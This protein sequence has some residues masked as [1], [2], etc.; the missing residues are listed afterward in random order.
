MRNSGTSARCLLLLLIAA[1]AL[2]DASQNDDLVFDQDG[3]QSFN[4]APLIETHQQVSI[5]HRL[6]RG[7]WDLFGTASSTA[8]PTTEATADQDEDNAEEELENAPP[9]EPDGEAEPKTSSVKETANLERLVHE[10]GD[11]YEDVEEENEIGNTAEGRREP[12]DFGNTDDEDLAGSGEV[13]GSA[14]DRGIDIHPSARGNRKYYRI[15]LTVGEP[16]RREYADRN[17]RE[18]KELSGNLTQPLEELYN[19]HIP[20]ENHHVNVVKIS[21]TSDSFTSQVTL[22][23]GSTFTDELEV[24]NILEQQLQY[25]S[26]GNIQVGPEGFTFRVFQADRGVDELEC[27][28]ST[29]LRCRDGA[30]V[31]LDSRCDGIAQCEDGSDEFDC[32]RTIPSGQVFYNTVTSSHRGTG[33]HHT[34]VETTTN[35]EE[36]EEGITSRPSVNKCRADDT[37]RCSDG[38]RS[39]CSVQQCDGVPDCDDGG[40][41]VDCPHPG[42]SAGE[43]ACDVSRCILESHRCNFIK[44][45]DDGSDEHDCNYPACTSTQFKCRNGQCIDSSAHCNGVE[46]CRDRTDELNCPCREDQFECTPGFCVTLN[47]RCDRVMDCTN[48]R[49]EE[50][51]S[52][53]TRCRPD[54]FTCSDGG[55]VSEN[56]RCDG[57]SDCRDRSDEY[58]CNVT[59]CSGDQ[60]RCLDG[61]CISIDKR[62]NSYIDCRN[63]EDENQCGCGEAKF[64]CTDGQCIGYELQCNGV[65]ECSD[66]SDE[67]DCGNSE[68]NVINDERLLWK[69]K[70]PMGKRENSAKRWS[71]KKLK[72]QGEN[73]KNDSFSTMQSPKTVE[74]MYSTVSSED[75]YLKTTRNS[76][77]PLKKPKNSTDVQSRRSRKKNRKRLHKKNL[78]NDTL[79]ENEIPMRTEALLLVESTPSATTLNENLTISTSTELNF[80][81]TSSTILKSEQFIEQGN[82]KKLENEVSTTVAST[83]S[84]TEETSELTDDFLSTLT[85]DTIFSEDLDQKLKTTSM[86]TEDTTQWN[87]EEETNFSDSVETPKVNWSSEDLNE[88]STIIPEE[89]TTKFNLELEDSSETLK[90]KRSSKEDL[91]KSL[92]TIFPEEVTELNSEDPSTTSEAIETINYGS[93][94]VSKERSSSREDIYGYKAKKRGD[95]AN[96]FHRYLS[97]SVT[98][99]AST[100]STA[101][102]RYEYNNS[103]VKVESGLFDSGSNI[104]KVDLDLLSK[105]R[106]S[107]EVP[108]NSSLSTTQA[109]KGKVDPC[110]LK[111]V[112][113]YKKLKAYEKEKEKQSNSFNNGTL[114]SEENVDSGLISMEDTT[115]FDLADENCTELILDTEQSTEIFSEIP[116]IIHSITSSTEP[117]D[118]VE[119]IT[120]TEKIE[121]QVG[122]K[123]PKHDKGRRKDKHPKGKGRKRKN[124]HKNRVNKQ[125]T[126]NEQHKTTIGID[127][128]TWKSSTLPYFDVKPTLFEI[129][130]GTY[131][132][133]DVAEFHSK[134]STDQ[135]EKHSQQE[136]TASWWST[137][138][139]FINQPVTKDSSSK[140]CKKGDKKA[141]WWNSGSLFNQNSEEDCEE[142]ASVTNNDLDELKETTTEIF[143]DLF[144]GTTI[145]WP[146]TIIPE[147]FRCNQDQYLCDDE[148]C[149]SGSQVC[150]G[151][152]DCKD[153]SDESN[154]GSHTGGGNRGGSNG[155]TEHPVDCGELSFACDGTCI[156]N[157]FLCDNIRHC[158]DGSDEADCGSEE[159]PDGELPCENG[160][161]INKNFFCDRNPDCHDGSDERDCPVI[162]ETTDAD[163]VACRQDEFACRHG[164]CIPQS[165]VCDGQNDCP[166]Q[167]DEIN[168]PR[169][170]GKDQFQCSNGD[171]IRADQKCNGYID[172]VDGS[173]EPEECERPGFHPMPGR[174][175]AGYIMCVSDKDCVPQSSLCNGIPECRDR[176]DEENCEQLKEPS[177]LNLKTYPSEQVIKENPAK[178]GR[179]VVFQCRDEGPLRARVR[180]LRGNNLPLPPGSRDLNGRL[181]IPN[182]Q[183]DHGGLYICE[184]VGYPASTTGQQVN[185]Y[186]TVEK[187]EPPATNKPH[188]CQYDEATCSNGD[189]IPKS[190]V[191]NGRLDCTDGSDEMRCSPHGCEPNEFRCNNTQ[192][193]SKL[194]RCDGDKDCADGSD[195]ENCVPNR[196]GSP[197]RVTE[198]TCASNDQCIPK[199]YHCDMEKDCIDG[200]DEIGCSPVYIMKPPPPMITLDLGTTLV[201]VCTAIGVPTPEI[202]WRLNWGHIPPKCTMTS[203]NGTGTLTCPDIQTEDQGAYSCEALNTAGFVFAVPDAIVMVNKPDDV[204]PKGTF[205]SEARTVE[206][207]ISCFCFGVAT[208]CHSANLFTYQIPPPFD[209]HKI[210]AVKQQPDL[211]I[212]N[213]IS[214]QLSVKPLGRD[215]LHLD[216]STPFLNQLAAEKD[217]PYFALPE[218]FH[219]SQLKSYGGY[220]KYRVRYNG[221]GVPNSAPAVMLSG[222]N[223]L[224]IHKGKQ[225]IPNYD[226]DESVRFFEGEWLKKQGWSEVPATRE[227]IMMTLANVDNILIK[228]EYDNSP[229]LDVQLTHIVMDTADVRNT[230]LGSASFVEECQCPSG[231]T[232]LSCEECAPGYLRRKTGLWLGQCYRDEPI[233]CPPG[234]YG[235]PSRNIP[236][237]AC[238]CPL[239]NPSNQFARTCHLGSDG[240]PTCNCPPGYIGR[241]CEQCDVGYQGNPLIPGDMCVA[242]QQ[243]DPEGSISSVVDPLT[244]KCRCKQY[245]TGITCNQCKANTFKNQFG[246]TSCF[247][248]GITNKC[249]SSN[250]YRNDV[251]VSFTNSIRDFSLIE[252][253]TPNPPPIVDGIRLNTVTREIIYSDFPNRGN[254]DVYYWQ[255]PSIFLGDQV[256]SYGGNLKYTVRYVPAPGGQSSKNNAAD[257]ELI[258]ANDINLLYFSRES[259]EPNTPQTF[260]VPLLEQYWQRNDGTQA[261]R[262]HLLMALADVSAIRIKATYTTHT[263]EA[264]LSLVSLDI[265]EKYNTGRARAV[266][267]EECSCPIGYKGLSCEDCDVGYTRASE[268]L[269]LGICEQCNCNGHSAQCNPDTGICEN[270]ADH[271]TGDFCEVCEPG[272]EGDAT[273]GT[274]H[275]CVYKDSTPCRCNEAGS[276]SSSCIGDRCD[277]KRNVEGPQCNRCRPSTFGLSSYNPDGCTECYCSGVTNQCHESSLYVQQIPVWVY[278]NQHGFTLT[279]STRQEIIDDGFELNFAMNEIGYRYPDSRGRRLFWSLPAIFTGNKVKS[280]GG[281]LTLTQH[282]TAHPGA[283]SYKDQDIILIG[284]GITLFW[285]NPV[286]IQPD[287]PLT[288]SVPL[289]ESEWR[290]LTTEGPRVASRIDLMTVLSNLEAILVRATHSERMTATYISDISLDTAVEHQTGNRR[291]VQV[292]VCRCPTGHVGT[293]CESCARGYYRDPNDRS[294]SYL[295]SCNP[296]PCNNNEESCEITR[297]G[298]VKCHCLP[299]YTGQYCLSTETNVTTT[300]PYP[301]H[302]PPP[303]ILVYIKGPEFQIVETGSTV[304]YHCA[305]KSLDNGSLHIKWEKEG[306]Q[307][308]PGRTVDD[309]Q[310]LLVIRDV[311]VSDSGVYVCQVSDGVHIGYK[312][313]TLTVGGSNPVAPRAVVMPTSLEVMEGQPAEFRCM[314]T[315][316]PQPQIE[317]I[318]IH[319]PTS[320]EVVTHNGAW[321]LRAA[322]KNDAAEYKCI[323]RNNVG[324]DEQTVILYVTDNPSMPPT[325]GI[326]PTITPSQW[327]GT[328]GDAVLLT[329]SQTS[330]E[331]ASLVWLRQGNLPF[332]STTTQRDGVLTIMNSTQYDSG[333]YICL[334][335]TYVGTHINNTAEITVVPRRSPPSIKVRPEKQT[336]PQGSVAE[337]H[338]VT[339]GEPG[340]Q[341]KWS[342]YHHE[343]LSSNVQQVG[344]TL[345]IVNIQIPDRG[346]YVCHVT[347]PSGSHESSA[348]IEV[349]PREAPRVEIYPREVP[350]V[351]L[352]GST[353]LQC[354]AVAGIP[355]PELHWSHQNGRPF[356]SNIKQLP[357]GVLRLSNI[358]ANDGGAY[359]C[360][361]VNPVGSN[362]AVVYIEVQSVP[363]IMISPRSGILQVK[364][365][366][367]VKLVCRSSGY[368]QPRVA[369][370]KHQNRID[371]RTQIYFLSEAATPLEAVY[372]INSASPDDEG[373]YTCHANNAA[374]MV[375]ERVYIRVEDNEVYPP[376]EEYP[377]PDKSENP[378]D[379]KITVP[380]DYFKIPS[381]GKVEMRCYVRSSDGNHI[382]LDWKRTDHRPLPEG[383]TVHNGILNIPVADK[384][385][386]GEYVCLGMDQARNVL[387]RAKS[388]LEVLSPPRIVLNPPRQTVRAGENPSID[389]STTGDEPMTIQWAAIGRNLPSSVTQDRGVLQFHGITYSDAGKYV[390]TATN[391]AGT[392]EAVAE[393]LVN[394]HPFDESS[395]VH[396]AQRDVV[397]Y[398]GQPVRLR[399]TVNVR[400]TI[401]WSRDGQPLPSTAR[402]EE[403][404]LELPRARPE[405]SGRYICQIQTVH[406]VSSDY[407]NLNVSLVNLHTE[408]SR[409]NRTQ[410]S[411]SKCICNVQGCFLLDYLCNVYIRYYNDI[412][413]NYYN[414]P[415]NRHYL[416][417]R[418]AT[419]TPAVSVEASQNP[420]NIGDTVNIRCACSGTHNPRYHWIRPNHPSLPENAQEYGNVLRLTNVAVSDSGVYRCIADTPEG[421]FDHDFNLVV[422]DGNNDAPAIETKYAPYGSSLE[423]DCKP[424]LNPPLKFHWSKLGGLLPRDAQ[425]FENKLKLINV[426]AEDAGTYVC[427]ATN[428]LENIEIPTVLVVTGVVPY[429]SQAPES[430]I[431]LP[432]LPDSY[433]K[434]NIEISFK[435]E[436]YDGIILYNDESNR[437]N[438]DFILLS[439]VGGYP[440]FSF[441]LGSGPTI[442]R[443]EKSVTLSEWHTIKLQRNRKE[444][445]MLVDGEGPY[446]GVAAGRKQGLDLKALL[447]VGGVPSDNTVNK[448]AEITSG[449]V[450]C[451]SRLVIGEKE[452]DLIDDQ[453]NSVGITNCETCAENPCNNAGVCQEAATKNGYTCLCRAGY[454]GKHCDYVGQSCYPGACG[455]GTCVDK[456]TG[457][458]CYCPHGKTG[459]RCEHSLTIYEPA[460]HDDKSFI[461][462]ET[463]KALRRTRMNPSY[464]HNRLRARNAQVRKARS[465][466]HDHN[467]MH[468]TKH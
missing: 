209:R 256:T 250:W 358:T 16:Y 275:D 120:S 114:K 107:N 138:T 29:E 56:A 141:S 172:C 313:V 53:M 143:R 103:S 368:P 190:Y 333:V 14:T 258:S 93:N 466:P 293:S 424:N 463:P 371:F 100:S 299:G 64:R 239:T 224:L 267:V 110:T 127:Q 253:R 440:V 449:F 75:N 376:E 144:T 207:C 235:D 60:F 298:Q 326:L 71:L 216:E 38:S 171:C 366:D 316:H 254:N 422:H 443:S 118:V 289:R 22:D 194:W 321:S 465:R 117:Q 12:A 62:C 200:S 396:A 176:S 282:I 393:V 428:N 128:S 237:K 260:T 91:D 354:R 178:Q 58:N 391:D 269:Y 122:K 229:D 411:E 104:S 462:H 444:G 452:I 312:N 112:E 427:T 447:F 361:A 76:Q 374:G 370:S 263:D 57:R 437:G 436:S 311:K 4:E 193:V 357:G 79:T 26:L 309:S 49:D 46:D 264:A 345:R 262:E 185:V 450:G 170:C 39:I 418:R 360:S 99:S 230:G 416:Q 3:K 372:E 168:C 405:D 65:E 175:P 211:R 89:E 388:H 5:L 198:Y 204:C 433:L 139:T 31:P 270:C 81:R 413:D 188:A 397:T 319:G 146:E 77:H 330:P 84:A 153:S 323:A 24:R 464:T 228:V 363:V 97:G 417:Q 213:D 174:C 96:Y 152:I 135:E 223:Y 412:G 308:P 409:A 219:G 90:I 287:I 467:K 403:D 2:V 291:A 195:E 140:K 248:M 332:S 410:C 102:G 365:G 346:V 353:D 80:Q 63:G 159:C 27:D 435:P 419:V 318:R 134:E 41:E 425:I 125:S 356:P 338:C 187:F 317:W 121:S 362:T 306:G 379:Q 34:E 429:F 186:L 351:I 177:R 380:K 325:T 359:V 251:R 83:E 446:K 231:Y 242:R 13:E 199:S 184:A 286:D 328:E 32:P 169:G 389:C 69:N 294:A 395:V 105:N 295:G 88:T 265:A 43:F 8:A 86:T 136:T 344:D 95:F 201:I 268:G 206:E 68:S 441:D 352:G 456:E 249:V 292:E 431:A 460:F 274:P 334:A 215:G 381:G 130:T 30:C 197:C 119:I 132:I 367:R 82:N 290:R 240:Q 340:L 212:L 390:C 148:T 167:E 454:S 408:C 432:P 327:Y 307:L 347:G 87:V 244:G 348:V 50:N 459:S 273:R 98:P 236:C 21:P 404:Y 163:H 85:D 42:C 369:W 33:E 23:I 44:E 302:I 426:K 320:P 398:A 350:P 400:A 161:C 247:C 415:Q 70:E 280:Y 342:K 1:A 133:R 272:Y 445:T 277:C 113:L 402:I 406:G 314:A 18:Y 106:L 305:G 283:Q 227:D 222:N 164:S 276:R 301:H 205:N 147:R 257:V 7:I 243:C 232:G 74:E 238:P 10:R 217:V 111:C 385:A 51:C 457:F 150:N 304:R 296:C 281:N 468:H 261:D 241:R 233:D 94:E 40:D 339:S 341:V 285:T 434:F 234:Y 335:T 55:C 399:C 214:Y 108:S 430:F 35:Q 154:C 45:C 73:I 37:V 54:E 157:I 252:S 221:T 394:E 158:G 155:S 377:G 373:S 461:A 364:R 288:Y 156:S 453:T 349:E 384:S 297:S 279:D 343:R 220:L 392:A 278:D 126:S 451:I 329:C 47:R 225:L 59:T 192:C 61:T 181:E 387:F 382:Y 421:V 151:I 66:G 9:G 160:V 414:T 15:T 383:S 92:R 131:P 246:C 182:I 386:A 20:N 165:A 25:H 438:G 196:P 17:S 28:Q 218:N 255:L 210:V 145:Q 78:K 203:I 259:P 442:I 245:A 448:Y 109:S 375:E 303:R 455:E 149:I 189:C 183:L 162:D 355:M 337:V 401:H 322:S 52:N 423:M 19:R 6:K 300:T 72:K 180:W 336:V 331:L 208:E 129:G 179:E 458:E 226:N 67:R 36:D 11:Q 202:N 142:D 378:D 191:C 173:D 101:L 124:K 116:K 266:E 115:P 166:Y 315:G 284:N 407:I 271:T 324:V 137:V 48:G 123:K 420:V 310:G 439:L